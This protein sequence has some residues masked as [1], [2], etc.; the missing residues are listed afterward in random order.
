MNKYTLT[1]SAPKM[2]NKYQHQKLA[3]ILKIFR[4]TVI[5]IILISLIK[6]VISYY[7]GNSL[8]ILLAF[9]FATSVLITYFLITHYRP[10][11]ARYFLSILNLVM[12][13]SH[14]FVYNAHIYHPQSGSEGALYGIGI[15]MVHFFLLLS[16]NFLIKAA[17]IT[18]I[19]LVHVTALLI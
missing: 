14:F 12:S 17:T 18:L 3:L 8:M 10:F 13:T 2:E 11:Y 16:P 1:F 6:A 4:I 9:V 15:T 7:Q 19:I 5:L